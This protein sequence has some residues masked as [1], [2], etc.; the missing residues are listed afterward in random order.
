MGT[1]ERDWLKGDGR[2]RGPGRGGGP[3][4]YGGGSGVWRWRMRIAVSSWGDKSRGQNG[5]ATRKNRPASRGIDEYPA[6]VCVVRGSSSRREVCPVSP[7]KLYTFD[8]R[9]LA[10]TSRGSVLVSQSEDRSKPAAWKSISRHDD[11]NGDGE[12]RPGEQGD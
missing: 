1:S 12:H 3:I 2:A 8:V 7:E 9:S 10:R 5:A 6:Y 4:K 11:G